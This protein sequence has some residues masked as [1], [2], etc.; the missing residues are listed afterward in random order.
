MRRS[1]W[2][3]YATAMVHGL[4]GAGDMVMVARAAS[5]LAAQED[6][7]AFEPEGEL[8]PLREGLEEE[9]ADVFDAADEMVGSGDP[10]RRSRWRGRRSETC[11]PKC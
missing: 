3:K 4:A 10:P 8:V 11:K 2:Q 5:V 7:Q 6:R 9:L 1:S